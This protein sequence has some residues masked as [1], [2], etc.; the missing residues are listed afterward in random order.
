[1]TQSLY[2]VNDSVHYVLPD[3][4][5]DNNPSH[6]I[7]LVSKSVNDQKLDLA[8]YLIDKGLVLGE[9]T[10]NSNLLYNLQYY[11][12]DYYYFKQ[13]YR[14]AGQWYHQVLPGFEELHDTLMIAKTLNSVGLIYSFQRDNENTLKYYLREV[15]L[16]DRVKNKNRKLAVEQVVVL[17]NIINLYRVSGQYLKV[18]ENALKA[19]PLATAMGDSVRLATILNSLG[20]AYKNLNEADK[21]LESFNRALDIF[22]QLGD[23]YRKPFVYLNIGGLYDFMGKS[24]SSLAYYKLAVSKFKEEGYWYGL[25][26]AKSGLADIYY[27]AGRMND[28]RKLYEEAIDSCIFYQFNDILIDS[29]DGLAKLE[30]KTGN[31]QRAYDHKMLAVNLKDSLY[32]VEKDEQYAELQ[33]RYETVQKESEINLLKSEKMIQQ[34]K[35][36]KSKFITWTGV[37]IIAFLLAVFY[38]GTI[39][40]RQKRNANIQLTEKNRQIEMKNEQLAAMNLNITQMNEQLQESQIELTNAN[41]AKDRFFSILAHDLR[42][43]FHNIMGE[44]YLLSKT[45]D[46]ISTEE[47]KKYASDILSSCEQVNRLLG[48]LLEWSKTQS[49]GISF[50]PVQFD[51]YQLVQNSLSVLKGG[52]E[53]K[54]I[55]LENRIT[56]PMEVF[57]DYSMLETVM[58][59]LVHNSIKFTPQ[60]GNITLSASIHNGW[61]QTAISDTGVGIEKEN[62]AK[63]FQIDSNVKTRGTNNE[64]G[65]GLGLVICKEFINYHKGEIWVES[66][67]GKGSVF[68]FSIPVA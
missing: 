68:H 47:R 45:Y 38:V 21:S 54:S 31:Y 10:K 32:T 67:L 55:F 4:F 9:K 27:K 44:S 5:N 13:D 12:A 43:P 61:L 29:Y 62:L 59:N 33:T 15:E 22:D 57:A 41:N 23:E 11:L 49:K 1:M 3:T 28:A 63:L 40:Y 36:R 19:I 30:Y 66:T 52:F 60:G 34:N 56:Q 16:L 26:S 17:T 58:R 42:N 50:Q 46:K 64:N 65:T 8:K 51:F 37:A 18:K 53:E 2:S 48:N 20:N 6:Y 35:L 39:F 25:W 7:T 24:D 14:K